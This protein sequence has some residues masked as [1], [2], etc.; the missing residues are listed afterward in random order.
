LKTKQLIESEWRKPKAEPDD[1]QVQH[2]L[3]KVNNVSIVYPQWSSS[4][5]TNLTSLLKYS[6]CKRKQVGETLMN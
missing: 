4:S 2:V 1:R 6:R 3:L 5:T